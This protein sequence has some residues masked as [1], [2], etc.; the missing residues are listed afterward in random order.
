MLK[1]RLKLRLNRIINE[2]LIIRQSNLLSIS[3]LFVVLLLGKKVSIEIKNCMN[4]KLQLFF[5]ACWS[6]VFMAAATEKRDN[7]SVIAH[8][9][10]STITTTVVQK[11]IPISSRSKAGLDLLDKTFPITD[12]SKIQVTS[13]FTHARLQKEYPVSNRILE[14]RQK[15]AAMFE[16]IERQGGWVDSFANEDI[17]TLPIGIKYGQEQGGTDFEIGLLHAT[18]NTQYI[19]FTA[20]AR[21]TLPQTDDQGNRIQLFFGTNNLK[22]SHQGGIVGDANLVLMGDVAIPFDNGSWMLRFKGG[23]DYKTGVTQNLTY[24]NIDCEGFNELGVWGEVQFSREKLLPATP[25][26]ELESATTSY[27]NAAGTTT[28]IPNRVTGSFGLV[29]SDW[30]DLLVE[31]N[32]Q[33]FVLT[34]SPDKFLFSVSKATLDFSD[35]RT[36]NVVFPEFY[37]DQGLLAPSEESWRGIYIASLRVGIPDVFKTKK[38]IANRGKVT[39]EAHHLIIDNYGVSGFVGV[40]NLIPLDEGLTNERK[41]WAMSIDSIGVELVASR[42]KAAELQGR[43]I[44]P[45]AAPLQDH[46]YTKTAPPEGTAIDGSTTVLKKQGKNNTLGLAYSGL[47]TEDEFSMRV[48]SLDTLVMEY[49]KAKAILY[50]NS[51][52]QLN[53]VDKSFRPKAILNGTLTLGTDIKN[54]HTA[55]STNHK[56]KKAIEFRGIEFQNLVLQTQSPIVKVD[57]FGYDGE[58]SIMNFPV[59][60]ANI[61]LTAND[62]YTSLGFDL[63]L[64]LMSKKDKGFA[65]ET[66]LELLGR[67]E[68]AN[69]KQRWKFDKVQLSKIAINA[70]L[71][72]FKMS[73]GLQIMRD[74]AEYGDGFSANLKLE[75]EALNGVVIESSAIFGKK[76]FRYWY[77]DALVDNLPTGKASPIGLKGFGGGAFYKMKRK[78]FN[79]SFSPSGLGYT[80]S[81]TH[82][83]GLKAMV[84]F[85]IMN[86][87][88]VNGGA[89]FEILFNRKGGISRMGLYGEAHI[90]QE[91]SFKNPAATITNKM[92]EMADKA[93]VTKVVDKLA[94][95]KLTKPFVDISKEEYPAK[96]EGEAGLHAYVGIEYDFENKILHGEADLYVDVAGGLIQGRASKG[97]AGWAVLHIEKEEWYFHMGTPE[98][99]LGL[100]IGIGPLR[101]ESGGYFMIGDYMPASPPPPP[102]VARIL[103]VEAETLNYMRD[104]NALKSGRGFAFGQDFKIDT[105]DLRFLMFYARF[106]AGGGYDI[107]LRDYGEAKCAN[108]GDQVGINGWYANGQAYAYLQGELGIRIKLFF[109]KK[110]IPIIR[111][112]AAVLLQ[113]K[114][115]N[116]IWMRGYLG[117]YYDLLGGLVKGKFRFKVS[118]GEECEFIDAAP[119]GG[120]K[121]I[122]DLTPKDG[123]NEVDVFAAPQATFSMP[124]G[125]PIVIPEEEEDKTY[126]VILETFRIVDETGKEIKGALEWGYMKDRA[127]FFS[128]DILPPQKQLTVEVSVSFQEKINGSFVVIKE[129]GKKAIETEVRN[130]VTGEAPNHIPLHNIT[131]SYPVVEQSQLYTS[132]STKGYVQLKRGQD[133]LFEDAQWDSEIHFIET[134]GKTNTV[135]FRYDFGANQVQFQLPALKKTKTYT[136]QIVSF[137]KN[138]KTVQATSTTTKTQHLD[139]DATFELTTKT[140]ATISKEGVIDRLSYS[141]GTSKYPTFAAKVGSIKVKN[142]LWGRIA[143]DVIYLSTS[144]K[145]HEGFEFV[146]LQGNKFTDNK[147]LVVA[148]ATLSDTYFTA[149]I[150]PVL[151]NEYPENGPIALHRDISIYGHVPKRALPLMGGYLESLESETR[152]GWRRTTFP[153]RY[154]LTAIYA[155]DFSDVLHQVLNGVTSTSSAYGSQVS[156]ILNSEFKMMR[157][158]DYIIRLQYVLP[159]GKKGTQATFT[160]K[161]PLK[162]R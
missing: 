32:L 138:S 49:W 86:D 25:N 4:R 97:R 104:E 22:I 35:I 56:A 40:S 151:Y 48:A 28:V 59:S 21:L 134:E 107:M 139:T 131:Y 24:A 129:D 92:K 64:N 101:I 93:G 62:H 76:E 90:M 77:V 148:E 55:S 118:L 111:A 143:S 73:G 18:V 132:E 20:F 65:A 152:I 128:E 82:G 114:A 29:V 110:K 14:D 91:F 1:N 7:H 13:Q 157:Y 15:A 57:Y 108:T 161:N 100:K 136:Y 70:D 36:E 60:I 85:S 98:D 3:K 34:K 124:I 99:R 81:D 12:A 156:S 94:N 115:P 88:A 162:D 116:P 133:Y 135:D 39:F 30:N 52:I 141:F 160:Y 47:I 69:Y 9:G 140:A 120:I 121:M 54:D 126:K 44:V 150:N 105:G 53:V 153:Y 96:I 74:N 137:P 119:L 80:P 142:D 127:T 5:L 23:F 103:G 67:I 109:V 102:E 125:K 112:G 19:E 158:G 95:N 130:F 37:Y 63:R 6:C 146:E 16:T 41:A 84:L 149:D 27:T 71:G 117:G 159:G 155:Q 42:L 87:K 11:V 17:Q 147:P 38:T 46:I 154:N 50:P 2:I 113:A 122:A 78:N 123:A 33:P 144:I 83:L 43:I 79:S 106:V 66:R 51:E 31:I 26:G 89:G 58:V 61:A 8:K 45:I 75:L 72:G 68:D 10:D 145:D